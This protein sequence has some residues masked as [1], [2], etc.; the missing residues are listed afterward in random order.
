MTRAAFWMAE[1]LYGL[2]FREITGQ[3]PVFHPEVRV[4]EVRDRASDAYVGLFYGD[5]F[6]RST[7]RSGAWAMNYQGHE[8][9]T[10]VARH[11]IVSNNNN[12]VK[13]GSGEPVL[14]SVDDAETLFHEFGHALHGL[15]S[16]VTYPGLED[17][18]MD[19][20]EFPSQVHEMWVL[21]R[22]VLDRFARH[23]RTGEPMPPA[24]LARIEAAK[25]FNQGYQTVEYLSGAI[26][27]ME[28]HMKPDGVVEPAAFERETLERIGAPRE[29][30]MRHRLPQFAHL[31]S[32]D[33][34]SAGYYSYLW[35]ELMDADAREAFS[36]TGDVFD[37]DTA[38]KL[39]EYILAPGNTTDR[40]EA[41]RL[42]RGR[43]PEV[44]A[45]LRKRGFPSAG[46]HPAE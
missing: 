10:G 27:D 18:P 36:E 2:Q 26:V 39:R 7:K 30:A 32:G 34:Y 28:L 35:S 1:R 5:Y 31:F 11:P 38:R 33:G 25:K 21:T 14:I 3:V 19:F 24:L 9:F 22:P 23:Y 46:E 45:L 20:V 43:N 42:F 6:A 4:W 37:P 12:F 13:G 29:V 8:T 16:R 40:A 15:L 17:T 41:Y 44:G